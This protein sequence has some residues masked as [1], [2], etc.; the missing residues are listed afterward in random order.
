MHFL[1]TSGSSAYLRAITVFSTRPD[2]IRLEAARNW[3]DWEAASI[4]LA[5]P[6][7]LPGRWQDPGYL[8]TRARII[9]HYFR[10]FAWLDD[11]ILLRNGLGA[12]ESLARKQA[13]YRGECRPCG[14]AGGFGRC[15]RRRDRHFSRN[16]SKIVPALKLK[17]MCQFATFSSG[18]SGLSQVQTRAEA[19]SDGK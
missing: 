5:D 14:V 3:H 2:D 17:S 7:G 16:L 10:N 6:T 1:P 18:S 11:G 9:T 8:L 15:N 4:I 19:I 12:V 13:C